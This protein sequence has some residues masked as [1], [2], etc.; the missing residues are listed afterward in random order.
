MSEV[1]LYRRRAPRGLHR[2]T[3]TSVRALQKLARLF[4]SHVQGDFDH[5]KRPPS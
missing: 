5:K 2:S 1:P 3:L 4:G